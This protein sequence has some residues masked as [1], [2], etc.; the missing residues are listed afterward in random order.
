MWTGYVDWVSNLGLLAFES[1]A[2]PI[3]LLGL[4]PLQGDSFI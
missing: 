3:V 1:Y 4:A 2:L